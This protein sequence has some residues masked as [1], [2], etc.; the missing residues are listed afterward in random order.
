MAEKHENESAWCPV[1]N[2]VEE[3]R[4]DNDGGEIKYGT[5]HFSPGTKIYCLPAQWGDG[6]EQI[7]VIGRHR[8]SKQYVTMV[9]KSEWVINWRAK[10]VYSP[11]VLSRLQEESR[12]QWQ[13]QQHVEEYVTMMQIREKMRE[14]HSDEDI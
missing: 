9:I 14:T 13:S 4:I 12:A 7:K 2:I 6:Y 10:V 11:E 3:R 8:G 1:G 5:K